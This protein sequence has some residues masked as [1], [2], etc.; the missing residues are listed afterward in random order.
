MITLVTGASGHVGVNLVRELIVRGRKVRILIHDHPW[1]LKELNVE[2][3]NGDVCDIESLNRAFYGV[4]SVYHL[5]ARISIVQNNWSVLEKINVTGTRNVIEACLKS[6]VRRL[7]HFSSIHALEQKPMNCPVDESRPLVK[8]S[9]YP[10]YDRSKAAGDEEILRG[11]EKGLDAIIINPT[12]IAGPYDYQLSLF[13]EALLALANGRLPA[14]VKGGFDWVDARDVAEGAI[15]AEVRA[16][17]GSRY[18]LSGHWASVS[19]IA[20]LVAEISGIP[21][22]KF[23]CPLWLAS[24]SAPLAVATARLLK[25]RPLFTPDSI[26]AL[27][28]NRNV[29][30]EK[31]T[32]ELG[33]TPRPLRQTIEDTLRWFAING[34]LKKPIPE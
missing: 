13:G 30:H 14:L 11:I 3:V 33:Y 8:S 29:N 10:P 31:A 28:S 34:K 1:P 7:I 2:V 20:N 17:T 6:G 9:N 25:Q 18:L 15:Q 19:E 4:D 24:A 5:A 23:V 12:A 21:V 26:R 22:P 32:R 27:H 16:V